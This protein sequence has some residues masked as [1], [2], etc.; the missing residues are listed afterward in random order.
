MLKVNRKSIVVS[1]AAA[2]VA[3]FAAAAA[4]QLN[5]TPLAYPDLPKIEVYPRYP[6]S[7][8]FS[9]GPSPFINSDRAAVSVV[10]YSG[11]CQPESYGYRPV[12]TSMAGSRIDVGPVRFGY[13]QICGFGGQ[14]FAHVVYSAFLRDLGPGTYQVVVSGDPGD[15]PVP[16]GIS[17][18]VQFSQELV[19]LN[20]DQAA[21]ALIENPAQGTTQSGVGLI[22]GWAC[23]ADRIEISID[24]GPRTKVEGNMPRADVKPVCGHG[25]GGFGLLINFNTQG[26]LAHNSSV[27]E[28]PANRPTDTVQRRGACGGIPVGGAARI[29]DQQLPGRGQDSHNRLA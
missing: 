12:Q 19:V 9:P 8:T 18:V 13:D 4:A 28:G 23:V 15:A 16:S 24:G 6:V 3:C 2:A 27:C 14:H 25:T 29:H 5:P 26:W 22:S 20:L 11:H 7:T 21:K 10:I 17:T 1:V